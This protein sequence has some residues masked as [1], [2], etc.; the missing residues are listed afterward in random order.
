MNLCCCFPLSSLSPS[1]LLPLL[2]RLSLPSAPHYYPLKALQPTT[3]RHLQQRSQLGDSF[4]IIPLLWHTLC[5]VAPPKRQPNQLS[6]MRCYYTYPTQVT[7]RSKGHTRELVCVCRV[8]KRT[9]FLA[10]MTGIQAT[11]PPASHQSSSFFFIISF[12]PPHSFR[13]SQVVFSTMAIG[14]GEEERPERQET[15]NLFLFLTRNPQRPQYQPSRATV[16]QALL[17]QTLVHLI[18]SH[19]NGPAGPNLCKGEKQKKNWG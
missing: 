11:P 7:S 18:L 10:P 15:T 14:C 5:P 2:H 19:P 16:K 17:P 3:H 9:H 1:I 8:N 6:S 4:N 12:F 13:S